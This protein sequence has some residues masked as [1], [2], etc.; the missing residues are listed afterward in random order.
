MII[1]KNNRVK[2]IKISFT[3]NFMISKVRKIPYKYTGNAPNDSYLQ[4]LYRKETR[5]KASALRKSCSSFKSDIRARSRY[6][7]KRTR[8]SAKAKLSYLF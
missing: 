1:I 6:M 7:N 5:E 8:A 4:L 2:R 3:G